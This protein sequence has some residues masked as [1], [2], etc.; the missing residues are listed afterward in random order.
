MV[1]GTYDGWYRVETT[2][3]K[4]GWIYHDYV[5]VPKADKLHELSHFKAKKASDNTGHQT[6]YGN[7]QQL[8][9]YYAR[10]GAP[11]AKRGLEKQGVRLVSTT[12]APHRVVKAAAKPVVKPVVAK[13]APKPA[14]KPVVIKRVAKPVVKTAPRPVIVSVPQP[15]QVEATTSNSIAATPPESVLATT[16]TTTATKT[17]VAATVTAKPAPRPKT[18][19]VSRRATTVR[20]T[21][22]RKTVRN[23]PATKTPQVA[24]MSPSQLPSITAEDIMAARAEHL[25]TLSSR[26]KTRPAPMPRA[27]PEESTPSVEATVQPSS[28]EPENGGAFFQTI[29]FKTSPV[30]VKNA[31]ASS[32]TPISGKP[33]GSKPAASKPQAKSTKTASASYSRGGSP[34]DMAAWA[35]ANNRFGNG[36]AKQALSYRGMP[37]ISG[38]SNPKRGFDCSGLVYY[39]LRQRGLN[40]PRTAAGLASYGKPVSRSSLKPGDLVLFANTYKRG[41]SHIGIYIGNNNFVHA[42]NHSSGVKTDSL[43]SAYYRK[44]Y[45]GARRVN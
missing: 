45:A 34:R 9:K 6:L 15:V 41:I 20:K 40:P 24:P 27:K 1:W 29:A 28:Y 5:N 31:Q 12:T 4:F 38:A 16:T 33:L 30:P 36:M 14:A 11:G 25:R 21:P 39:L 23:A 32:A 44:K 8:K 17:T 13:V 19:T 37:Y 35:K 10:Y 22:V 26:H 18:V 43:N 7:P 42:A 3:H 2:D